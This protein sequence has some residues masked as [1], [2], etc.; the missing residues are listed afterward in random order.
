MNEAKIFFV[1]QR[2]DDH[3]AAGHTFVSS[4]CVL[5]EKGPVLVLA[6]EATTELRV[7]GDSCVVWHFVNTHTVTVNGRRP[8]E[9]I[10]LQHLRADRFLLSLGGRGFNGAFVVVASQ[11]W[12]DD[13]K[14][15]NEEVTRARLY[16]LCE[17]PGP[18]TEAFAMQLPI[19][20][21]DEGVRHFD[22]HNLNPWA[23]YCRKVREVQAAASPASP[24]LA[25]DAPHG[26]MSPDPATFEPRLGSP[27]FGPEP[28]RQRTCTPPVHVDL[29]EE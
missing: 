6:P 13:V 1:F 21:S 19:E 23:F 10:V 9:T 24:E 17:L 26:V 4:I 7:P 27:T 29:T 8:Y 3:G 18:D 22:K 28:K 11:S 16:G 5:Y 14:G 20:T 25:V 12:C 2:A 15:D